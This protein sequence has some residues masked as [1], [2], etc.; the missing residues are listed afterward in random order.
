MIQR[1]T[2]VYV[3]NF[4]F[5]DGNAAGKRVWGNLEA[6]K[7]A[8]FN[9]V[10]LC[11]RKETGNKSIEKSSYAQIDL[12]TIPYTSGFKRL[13]NGFPKHV[14]RKVL[15]KYEHNTIATIMYNSL[16][17]TEFNSYVIQECHK[18]GIN[19]YYDI[20]DYFDV[21][22]KTNRL[23]YYMKKRELNHLTGKVLPACDG[24]ITISYFLKNMMPNPDKSIV[25]PPLSVSK[26]VYTQ[27][28]KDKCI[29]S[30][31]TYI[32][33][34]NRPISEWKDRVDIYIDV[35]I[36]LKEYVRRCP[37][38]LHLLG[39]FKDDLLKMFPKEIRGVYEERLKSLGNTVL[40]FGPMANKK[41]QEHIQQSDFTILFRDDKTSNNAGFPTK[42]SESI[43]LGV[44]P[45]TNITSDIGYYI[46]DGVNGVVVTKLD[47]IQGI[48]EKIANTINHGVQDDLR[49]GTLNT[50]DFY[51][52]TYT[53]R[54]RDFLLEVQHT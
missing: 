13:K 15:E 36:K 20:A 37:C 28:N 6:V 21:P 47:D 49:R 12:Y 42:I 44:P 51:Y 29:I 26:A 17:T 10:C 1:G 22:H 5:P 38:E 9:A 43:S 40:F 30:Y 41:V 24:W 18:R 23:R 46:Q 35:F 45:I 50:T 25:V 2:V 27:G 52:K 54:F 16:G 19:V 8:G 33:D 39:F 14:F 31:A 11:F 53:K 48:A 34:E 4:F 3:G 7:D 32:V